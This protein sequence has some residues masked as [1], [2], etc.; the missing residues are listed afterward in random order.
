M[1]AITI[2]AQAI[3]LVA[4]VASVSSVSLR[5]DRKLRMTAGT[6][7]FIWMIHFWLLG[8]PTTAAVAGLTCARQASSLWLSTASE[9]TKSTVTFVFYGAF[10]LAA[11]LTWQGWVSLLPWSIAML[12][13]FVYG[14]LKGVTMRKA[15]RVA[16][17]MAVTNGL[18]VG[19]IGAVLTSTLSIVINTATLRRLEGAPTPRAAESTA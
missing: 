16:D 3:G 5:C 2:L 17:C 12:C 9:R 19:S 14:H 13:N 11:V 6:G 8:A 7:Q 15:L 4:T 10:T 18:L 1:P